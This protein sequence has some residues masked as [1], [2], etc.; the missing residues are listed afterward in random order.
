MN[1]RAPSW[2]RRL[3]SGAQ[4]IL[5]R[6]LTEGERDQFSKYLV[7]L[8]KWQRSQRLVGSAEPVWVVDHLILDSLLYLPLLGSAATDVLD[9]GSGAGFPGVPLKIMAP[10]MR[11]TMIESRKRRAS[12]LRAVVR[13][14]DLTGATV[15]DERAEAVADELEGRFSAVVARCA[16]RKQAMM[17][18]IDK[19]LARPGLGIVAGPPDPS[20]LQVGQWVETK[21]VG[22]GTRR[23]AVYRKT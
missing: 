21:A 22:G 13:A 11:L 14:L 15:I 8:A 18:L 16:G 10:Q 5:G 2:E 19:L 4:D 7:L 23:F 6:G 9:I 20:P 12:F 1:P 17:P 3:D